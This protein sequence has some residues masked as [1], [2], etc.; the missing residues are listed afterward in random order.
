LG[1]V[2]P[3]NFLSGKVAVLE[4][5]EWLVSGWLDNFLLYRS[6]LAL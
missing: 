3:D 1:K 6:A 5:F 4:R 2:A